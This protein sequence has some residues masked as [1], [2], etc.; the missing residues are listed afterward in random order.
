MEVQ[1]SS[2]SPISFLMAREGELLEI[3]RKPPKKNE[4][5]GTLEA[6]TESYLVFKSQTKIGMLPTN[7]IKE[8]NVINF[9]NKCRIYKIDKEKNIIIV[10]LIPN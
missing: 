4:F 7:F 5:R 9:K 10:R 2:V 8:N 6:A 3:K 1:L